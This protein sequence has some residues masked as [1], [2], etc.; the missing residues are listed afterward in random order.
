MVAMLYDQQLDLLSAREAK[1]EVNS[2]PQ[3]LSWTCNINFVTATGETP[4][5]PE[6]FVWTLLVWPGRSLGSPLLH[7]QTTAFHSQTTWHNSCCYDKRKTYIF[8]LQLMWPTKD[9]KVEDK[10]SRVTSQAKDNTW[11]AS[12]GPVAAPVLSRL[13]G[14]TSHASR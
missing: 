9:E 8:P 4:R 14:W 5:W 7:F 3:T 12:H 2:L 1:V 13:P 11:E 6:R 10:L